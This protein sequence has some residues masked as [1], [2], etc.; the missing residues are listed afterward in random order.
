MLINPYI[1][2]SAPPPPPPGVAWNPADIASG[3]TLSGGNLQATKTSGSGY[4]SARATKGISAASNGYFELF[5]QFMPVGGFTT[6]GI[7]ALSESLLN[8]VGAGSDGWGIYA[9]DGNK[10]NNGTLSAYGSAI[11]QGAVIG[12]AMK[13]GSIWFAV[14]GVWVAG[15][16]PAAGTGAAFAGITGT[17]YPMVG[18][19]DT[20]AAV[21]GKFKSSDF[22]FAPPSGFSAWE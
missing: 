9:D 15:G 1:Y 4:Q 20:S 21:V 22:V 8:Y 14:G 5:N 11:V 17:M 7:A 13:S 6:F 19:F 16:D 3:V 2:G 12:V 18:L 10:I